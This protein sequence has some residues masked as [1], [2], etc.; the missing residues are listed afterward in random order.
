MVDADFLLL[1]QS[2]EK[3]RDILNGDGYFSIDNEDSVKEARAFYSKAGELIISTWEI[4]KRKGFEAFFV[5]SYEGHSMIGDLVT[6]LESYYYLIEDYDNLYKVLV[7][8]IPPVDN[9]TFFIFFDTHIYIY[10]S[11][12]SR[13]AKERNEQKAKILYNTLLNLKNNQNLI[14]PKNISTLKQLSDLSSTYF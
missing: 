9:V 3:I 10:L 2:L 1:Y 8:E 11:E 6:N 7:N 12:I 5:Q 4:V 13:Y 14:I